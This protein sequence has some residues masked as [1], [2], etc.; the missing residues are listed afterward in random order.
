VDFKLHAP[1]RTTIQGRMVDGKV[2]RLDVQPGARRLHVEIREP[3][4]FE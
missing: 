1:D 2:V 3:F 4:V